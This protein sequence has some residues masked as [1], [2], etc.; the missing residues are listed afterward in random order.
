MHD[1]LHQFE[2]NDVWSLVPH[3]KDVNII[4]TKWIFRNKTDE[5]ENVVRNKAK[6][7]AQ[8]Y[9]QLEGVDFDETFSPVARIESIRTLLA[10]AC[11]FNDPFGSSLFN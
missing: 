2:R 8:G 10:L 4:D 11:H 5:E 3:P 1:G 6:L 9:T 7:V